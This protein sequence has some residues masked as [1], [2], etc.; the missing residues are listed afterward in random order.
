MNYLF[1]GLWSLIIALIFFSKQ[2]YYLPFFE[3]WKLWLPFLLAF[4]ILHFGFSKIFGNKKIGPA[5]LFLIVLTF[6]F[7]IGGIKF[8]A[9]D[10]SKLEGVSII[11]DGEGLAMIDGAPAPEADVLIR[12]GEIIS[13]TSLKTSV[14]PPQVAEHFVKAKPWALLILEA[15]VLL[16]IAF[17]IFFIGLLAAL[18]SFG[19]EGFL[20]AAALG[21][22]PLS[23]LAFAMAELKIFTAG[24]FAAAAAI[25]VIIQFPF[26]KK[27]PPK[28]KELKTVYD[29]KIS[30]AIFFASFSLIEI[31]KVLPY[32]WDDLNIYSRYEKLIAE[33]GIFPHGIGSFAWSNIASAA[34][35][36]SHNIFLSTI[37][38]FATSVLGFFALRKLL[39]R[40]LSP[41]ASWLTSLL[42]YTL[43]FVVNQQVIDM[44]TDLPLF[45]VCTVAIDKFFDWHETGK[46]R[47]L[48]IL[49]AL[50]GLALA[51]KITAFLLIAIVFL[52]IIWKKQ[53]TWTAPAAALF[54][55]LSFLAFQNTFAGLEKLPVKSMG[56]AF[57]IIFIILAAF[58]IHKK[59]IK[60]FFTPC[61]I[62]G[63]ISAA[64]L[65]P[66]AIY[67]YFD[68]DDPNIAKAIYGETKLSPSLDQSSLEY[69]KNPY[70]V[71]NLDYDRYTGGLR[72]TWDFISIPWNSNFTPDFNNPIVDFS[73][74][75]L[76]ALGFY[77]AFAKKLLT[78]KFAQIAVLTAMYII[79]W[80]FMGNGVIWYGIAGF[81]GSLILLGQLL[82]AFPKKYMI[83]LFGLA[84]F[85]NYLIR[86]GEFA[87]PVFFANTL[88]LIS[89]EELQDYI[90]PGYGEVAKIID[91]VPDI[92]LYRVGTFIPYFTN[93]RDE[94]INN[95]HDLSQWVCMQTESDDSIK[96]IFK[97]SGLTHILLTKDGDP[98]FNT[99]DYIDARNRIFSFLDEAGWKVLYNEHGLEL[100]EIGN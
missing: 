8:F 21:L 35:L 80:M 78:P 97:K 64:V 7:V 28:I 68:S 87:P 66:W 46:K 27:F 19:G 61:L 91:A 36:F 76:A 79:L 90:F 60:N 63:L 52:A 73:F 54:L 67:N 38:L 22:L 51:I 45:F 39:Q 74:I 26:W 34:W 69:C 71:V 56:I 70:E 29:R 25:L 5:R 42:F 65:S 2:S 55:L 17:M 40:F 18:G 4:G 75:F 81:I 9:Y 15:K 11:R 72:S 77:A 13:D 32:A 62:I 88:G 20:A 94:Q 3:D 16:G 10:Y 43:P 58:S 96:S 84:F 85:S 24:N 33:Q 89:E 47:D 48:V 99:A 86:A 83:P 59:G 30:A 1:A 57:L 93:L 31:L 41:N 53:K 92:K 23:L 82:D 14:L 98:A 95:D 6:T 49:S 12:E 44:K 37:M 50:L 100:I